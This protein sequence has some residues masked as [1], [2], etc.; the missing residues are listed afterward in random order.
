M[1]FYGHSAQNWMEMENF[2]AYIKLKKHDKFI[3]IEWNSFLQIL[4]GRSYHLI[5]VNYKEILFTE[6]AIYVNLSDSLAFADQT[7]AKYYM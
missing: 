2:N 7:G 6:K 5:K 3:S 1:F 4:D